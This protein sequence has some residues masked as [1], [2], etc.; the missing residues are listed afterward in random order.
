MIKVKLVESRKNNWFDCEWFQVGY[1][2]D[3]FR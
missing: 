3:F 1:W 2:F